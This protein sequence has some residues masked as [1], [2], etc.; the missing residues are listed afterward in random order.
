MNIAADMELLNIVDNKDL[1][2]FLYS[3][4]PVGGG[5]GALLPAP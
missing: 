1:G 4:A 3:E 5:G 2:S